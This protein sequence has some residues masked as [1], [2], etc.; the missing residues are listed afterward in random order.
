VASYPAHEE[1][2][3]KLLLAAD[4]AMYFAKNERN[5]I[6]EYDPGLHKAGI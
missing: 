2:V 1:S 5:R 6:S 3:D 4:R